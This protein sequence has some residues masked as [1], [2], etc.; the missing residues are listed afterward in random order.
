MLDRTLAPDYAPFSYRTITEA[1]SFQTYDGIPVYTIHSANSEVVKLEL[2]LKSGAWYESQLSE[3]WFTA[4]ML[5]EGCQSKTSREISEKFERL[6]AFVEIDPGFDDVSVSVYGMR[7][8]FEEVLNLMLEVLNTPVFPEDEL[9]TLKKIRKDEI[10]LN[11]AKNNMHAS[12]KIRE[13]YFGI[14]HPYGKA[15]RIED[16][17]SIQAAQL[18]EYHKSMFFREPEL[19]ISGYVDDALIETVK[20]EFKINKAVKDFDELVVDRRPHKELYVER[21]ESLQSSIR[22]AWD[23]PVKSDKDYFDFQITRTV[24]GGYFGS[25]LMT[26]IREEKGY[27][28]GISA[29]PIHL[30]HASFGV[31]ATDVKAEFTQS[32]LDEIAFEIA[33]LAQ[34]E[35]G[36]DELTMVVNYLSGKFQSSLTTPFNLM[37]KFKAL[38]QAGLDYEHYE[39]YFE[40][41]MSFGVENLVSTVNKYFNVE[42]AHTVVVGRK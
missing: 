25:R 1:E 23:I 34:G 2:R 31:I 17:E 36:S 40:A 33:R 38:H 4:K 3:S 30:V 6:G 21:Q 16:I 22:L 29:Y 32:T 15:L 9:T 8:N 7:K 24:L 42:N 28:Y 18:S 11:D 26:N 19:F 27:T 5:M 12:K 20:Q 37:S 13:A 39:R 14:A 41:L 35:I 10:K